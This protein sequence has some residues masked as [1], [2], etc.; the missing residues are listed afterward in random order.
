MPTHLAD[1]VSAGQ[2]KTYLPLKNRV[3]GSRVPARSRIR[4]SA[5]Q[6]PREHQ[7]NRSPATTSASGVRYSALYYYRARHYD[8][9][10]GRFLQQDPLP[11]RP[12]EMNAYVYVSNNPVNVTDPLGLATFE[13]RDCDLVDEAQCIANCGP[14]G[15]KSCKRNWMKYPKP[16][17]SSVW[18]KSSLSCEC[19]PSPA[20]PQD[21][22]CRQPS[23][24]WW[25]LIPILTPWPDPI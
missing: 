1:R 13:R 12:A 8:P 17:G 25:L 16:D 19:N 20:W 24:P 21:N 15:V 7:K 3:W 2:G 6:V 10:V 14:R 11:P 9:K 18:Q 23:V 22:E 4:K 5:L